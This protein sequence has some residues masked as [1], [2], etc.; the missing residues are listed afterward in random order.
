[1]ERELG[2]WQKGIPDATMLEKCNSLTRELD[3][4]HRRE[5]TY[6]YA[7]ARANEL[8]DGDKNTSYFHHKASSRQKRNKIGRL[9]DP[10]GVWRS[11]EEDMLTVVSNYFTELFTSSQPDMLDEALEGISPLVSDEMNYALDEV[12][13]GEEIYHALNQMHPNKAPGLDGM[14]ALFYQKFWHIV[15]PDITVYVQ[16]WWKGNIDI[17]EINKTCIVLIPKCKE[18][19][20]MGD[21]RPISLCN[22]L[23]KIVSKVLANRLKVILPG[24]ISHHQSAFV[25]G[26]LITDNAMVAFEVFHAMKRKGEGRA[27]TIALKLD[28]SK[29]YD[30]VEW[31]CVERIMLHMG[32]SGGWVQR[33]M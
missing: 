14:H 33:V 9:K 30:R 24:L 4:L 1:M 8:R 18:P 15:G 13:T 19:E 23:Y 22:V 31:V 7:R 21:F 29:A 25:P 32:F 3:E 6:W 20:Q 12:P 5:E 2:E 27:G 28:M 10:E 17:S 26:R 16:N 11:S